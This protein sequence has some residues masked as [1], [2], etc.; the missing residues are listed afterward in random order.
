MNRKVSRTALSTFAVLL[1]LASAASGFVPPESPNHLFEIGLADETPRVYGRFVRS[2]ENVDGGL[3][4]FRERVGGVWAIQR[5]PI[6]G[7]PHHLLGSGV[8]FVNETIDTE[9][10]AS[11]IASSF[12]AEHADLLMID[13]DRLGASKTTG[14]HGKWVVL[15]PEQYEG[16]RVLGGRAHVVMTDKGRVYAVGSDFHPDI[17]IDG[18]PSLTEREAT[19]I[20][21]GDLGFLDGRDE[22][23][24]AELFVYPEERDGAYAYRLAWRVTQQ[25]EEPLGLWE[26]WIDARTGE[27]FRR[28][29]R[30]EFTDVT[31]TLRSI[32]NEPS[33]CAGTST[34]DVQMANVGLVG[35]ASVICD[36]AGGFT[37]T[38]AGVDSIGLWSSFFGP[39]FNVDYFTG[40]D[41]KDTIM[42]LPGEPVEWLWDD[43]NSD[44]AERDSWKHSYTVRN[45][46]KTL[47]PTFTGLDYRMRVRVNR[48][49]GYCP[50]N[51]W[52]DG[53][54]MN[55]CLEGGGFANTASLGDV[56]Y[57]EYGHGV[58]GR[59]Y[60]GFGYD[61]A[62]SEG[63]SDVISM[64]ILSN[65][66]LGTGFGQGSCNQG[67]RTSNNSLMYPDDLTGE[68]HADGQLIAAYFWASRA[69]LITRYGVPAA[70]SIVA[71]LWHFSRKSGHPANMEDQVTWTFIYD[72]NDGDLDTGTPN[73]PELSAA[74]TKKGFPVPVISAG[75]QIT[76]GGLPSTEDEF[77]PRVVTAVAQGLT[78]GIDPNSV[79]LF[80]RVDGAAFAEVAMTPAGGADEYEATLPAAP[81]NSRVQ[82]Y[83]E[84]A[85]SSFHV[86]WSPGGAPLGLH[87]YDV[88]F[89]YDPCES[90]GAWTLGDTADD[91]TNGVWINDEPV[92][93]LTRPEYDWTP[94]DGEICFVTGNTSNV[95]NGRTT[96]YSPVF[97]LSGKTDVTVR[98]SRWYSNDFEAVAPLQGRDDYWN[99]DVTND[100]G[101]SWQSLENT[102]VGTESWVEVEADLSVLYP[103]LGSVRFRFT[104]ADTGSPTRVHAAVDELR[105]FTAGDVSTSVADAEAGSGVPR[106]FAL[107]Q[108]R[109]NPF[110]PTTTIAYEIGKKGK[111][112]L[113]VFD[114]RGRRVRALVDDV[115]TAGAYRVSWD[116]KDDGNRPAGSGV[117]FYRLRSADGEI[118]KKMTL[119][120]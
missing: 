53:Q 111:V 65:S 27:I 66:M 75:V 8:D 78:T 95:K 63:N 36:S 34:Q 30:Y 44:K 90:L 105:I 106:A 67:I 9:A 49:D 32:V 10:R 64:I 114:V 46:M 108:N 6:L 1:G 87:T 21:G 69:N 109:P 86:N 54:G 5:D 59:L 96:L 28:E 119:L 110:N 55:F 60:G 85:D 56:V 74:A 81:M 71:G 98:Y 107:A 61:G 7:T 51:A 52:W 72:D 113:A 35:G 48:V 23:R 94:G 68:G 89:L 88:A 16:V 3:D 84:A 100:G 99:A 50:G 101:A 115:Q 57:H 43:A 97:D 117:Y 42:V 92:G 18:T 2:E 4:L 37:V 17:A 25:V 20:A 15:Y 93:N 29:N 39:D 120:R 22:Q 41:S 82:Y 45:F 102:N 76:H 77:S 33:Y 118:A 91:A 112:S 103:S 38:N 70:D 79:K 47:D 58:T 40:T 83:I 73:F 26:S 19:A 31:G 104:A 80:Y 24:G 116:G 11:E 12:L 62:V 13:P 14:G